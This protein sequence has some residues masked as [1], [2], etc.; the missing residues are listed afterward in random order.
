MG[1]ETQ[2]VPRNPALQE[3]KALVSKGKKK[4]RPSR[5]GKKEWTTFAAQ[6]K[7]HSCHRFS[8]PQRK[9]GGGLQQ[10]NVGETVTGE[11][12]SGG[13]PREKGDR[14]LGGKKKPHKGEIHASG[15]GGNRKGGAGLP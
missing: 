13:P 11:K 14:R 12:N 15:R 3:K 9:G 10:Q 7:N 5:G 8:F 2:V 6:G 4:G 1:E